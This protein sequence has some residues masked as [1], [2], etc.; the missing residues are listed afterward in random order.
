MLK[1]FIKFIA[2]ILSIPL[3]IA[4]TKAFLD[5][6]M[7]IKEMSGNMSVFLWGI[8]CYAILHIVAYKPTYLY[9][10]GHEAVHAGMSWIFGGKVKSFKVSKKGGSVAS[11]KT[12]TLIELGPYFVPIYAVIITLVYFVISQSYRINGSIFAFLIGFAMSFHMILTIEVLKVRQPDIVKSGYV[13]SVAL[14]YVLNIVSLSLI[15]SLLFPPF[16]AGSFFMD[17]WYTSKE[18]YVGTARQ[19]FF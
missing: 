1:L 8:A 13:F 2:G 19:L 17:V 3:A 18:M 15:F 9:V 5:N 12:N 4:V 7:L 11:T 10:L 14:I 6:S 16:S